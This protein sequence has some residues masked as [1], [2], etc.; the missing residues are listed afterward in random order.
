ME[1]EMHYTRP[2]TIMCFKGRFFEYVNTLFRLN[3]LQASN[4]LKNYHEWW[5]DKDIEEGDRELFE[6]PG[7]HGTGMKET[8]KIVWLSGEFNA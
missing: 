1:S 3:R 2:I 8:L 5:E 7:S 6:R 4:E